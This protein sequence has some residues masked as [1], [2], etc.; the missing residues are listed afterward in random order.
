MALPVADRFSSRRAADYR[1]TLPLETLATGRYLLTIEAQL[2]DRLSP[3]R[4]V[5]FSVR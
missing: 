5:P 2:G 4:D 1:M 3:K